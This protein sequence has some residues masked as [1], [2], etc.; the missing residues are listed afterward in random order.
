MMRT[1]RR[2]VAG[3]VEAMDEAEAEYT[4]F[5]RAEFRGVVQTAYLVL[6]D[7]QRAEDVAQEA[8]HPAAGALEEGRANGMV[9]AAQVT[10]TPF[11][12]AVRTVS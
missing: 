2:S 1:R 6:H 12:S 5:F 9:T 11:P 10:T 7:R 3:P 4:W 8:F